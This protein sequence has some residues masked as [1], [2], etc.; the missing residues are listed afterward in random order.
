MELQTKSI[1]FPESGVKIPVH[2]PGGLLLRQNDD[3]CVIIEIT[4]EEFCMSH[5]I[6]DTA[7]GLS[8][9]QEHSWIFLSPA[10]VCFY[11][12][13]SP[14]TMKPLQRREALE[15][16][17]MKVVGTCWKLWTIISY[18]VCVAQIQ[19]YPLGEE[20]MMMRGPCMVRGRG[21]PLPG[22]P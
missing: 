17:H 11:I 15:Y 8:P 14:H 2:P 13:P 7:K 21:S 6:M 19:C 22:L 9:P 20:K 5:S 16:S 3:K 1:I 12:F 18:C 4:F 10:F